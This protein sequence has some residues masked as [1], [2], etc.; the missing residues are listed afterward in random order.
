[1][2]PESSE[3]MQRKLDMLRQFLL[4]LEQYAALEPREQRRDH[5]A[6]ERLLQLLCE[7]S[8]DIGLQLLRRNGHRLAASYREVF[9]TLRERLDLDE[10][11]ANQLMDACAMRNVLTHLY[12]TIDLDRVIA[13]IVPAIRVYTD[14]A[15][16]AEQ[17]Q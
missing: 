5:Y 4:D 11:L 16:W 7:S 8:A 12:D 1:M 13:A 3:I 9:L 10:D 6:I 17:Q 15:R 2:P 14:F